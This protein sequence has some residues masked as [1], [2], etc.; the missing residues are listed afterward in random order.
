MT[1][2]SRRFP[3]GEADYLTDNGVPLHAAALYPRR[4]GP[5]AIRELYHA[6]ITPDQATQ[7]PPH[8]NATQVID[9]LTDP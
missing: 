2:R 5:A 4:F 6:G 7:A 8:L 1:E 9:H 3:C